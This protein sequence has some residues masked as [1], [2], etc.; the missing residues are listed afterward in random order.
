MLIDGLLYSKEHEWVKR[1]GDVIVMGITDHAQEMLGDIT[2]IELPEPGVNMKQGDQIAVV[3]S[4]KAASDVFSPVSGK[5]TDV[6]QELEEC[7]EFINESCYEKGWICKLT[8]T[9]PEDLA[10]LMEARQYEAFL[11]QEE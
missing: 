8:L 11:A 2:F 4:S 5:I 1:E 6:N 7:P 3:E 9:N 10:G